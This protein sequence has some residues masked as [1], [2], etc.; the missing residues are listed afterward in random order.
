MQRGNALLLSTLK[1][2]SKVIE[3]LKV[4]PRISH[5]ALC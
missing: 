2:E 1:E 3:E 4:T 5:M